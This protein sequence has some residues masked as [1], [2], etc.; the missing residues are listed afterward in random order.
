MTLIFK[1]FDDFVSFFKGKGVN[2]GIL[3]LPFGNS[4]VT[5]YVHNFGL[6][7]R[8]FVRACEIRG[9]A[10]LVDSNTFCRDGELCWLLIKNDFKYA[11]FIDC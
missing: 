7:L 3:T 4:K 11:K 9:N 5:T 10:S 8:Y 6:V 2:V 1:G